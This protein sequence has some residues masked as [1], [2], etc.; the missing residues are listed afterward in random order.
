M[1]FF[2]LKIKTESFFFI[3]ILFIVHSLLFNLVTGLTTNMCYAVT[4]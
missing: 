3:K 4:H 1:V 2:F